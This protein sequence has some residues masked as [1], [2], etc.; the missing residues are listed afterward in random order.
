MKVITIQQPWAWAIFEVD[1][2]DVENRSACWSYEGPVIVVAGKRW[3]ERGGVDER[4]KA[5]WV[6]G[7]AGHVGDLSRA[8]F[9]GFGGP[10]AVFGAAI[11]VV[12]VAGC[13]VSTGCHRPWGEDS[14]VEHGSGKTRRAHHLLLSEARP[15]EAPVPAAGRLGLTTASP[16]LAQAVAF[17]LG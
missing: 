13:H 9:A 6:R 11:G 15:L 14:Y 12:D 5:L 16:E 2:K 8:L 4:I 1:G 10:R 3:S 7:G 17:G